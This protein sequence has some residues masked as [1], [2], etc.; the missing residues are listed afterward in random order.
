MKV[1][2]RVLERRILPDF[3]VRLGIRRLLRQ[4]L[5]DEAKRV[6]KFPELLEKL[7][8]SPI[9]V[10]TREANAQHYEVPASFLNWSWENI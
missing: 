6:E 7:K 8:A 9:A 10:N 4:R 2:D 3:V 5:R 1:M